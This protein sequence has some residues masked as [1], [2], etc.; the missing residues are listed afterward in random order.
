MISIIQR[1]DK[2]SFET[3]KSINGHSRAMKISNVTDEEENSS[4]IRMSNKIRETISVSYISEDL[5]ILEKVDKVE[6]LKI[7]IEGAEYAVLAQFLE[8]NVVCQVYIIFN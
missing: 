1:P 2:I 7:D 4:T 8:K 6:I 5:M 3:F